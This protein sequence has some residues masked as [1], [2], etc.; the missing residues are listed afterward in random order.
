MARSEED[1]V[2]SRLGIET[3]QERI[4][5]HVRRRGYASIEAM[6][7]RF[8]V[9]TQTIRRDIKHLSALDLLERYH[10][11]AGLPP[12]SD[13]L[14]YSNRKV[15][16]AAAKQSVARAV[17]SRIP[18]GSSLFIDI[19]TTMEAV[20]EALLDHEGLTV[21]TNHIRV[22]A[23]LSQRHDFVINLAGGTVR[24]S[25]QAVTGEATADFI[26]RFKVGFGIF[27][28][29]CIDNDGELLDYDYRDAQ[30]SLAA[31]ANARHVIFAAD[32][33]KFNS[34]AMVRLTHLSEIDALVTNCSP[35]DAILAKLKAN[36]VALT[37]A[38][39]GDSKWGQP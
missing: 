37:V 32:D 28:I 7:E 13:K 31:M 29:G 39:G 16:N 17:A 4:L 12:G 20:A 9:S 21:V 34:D 5:E 30:T 27:S 23:I 25:D 38:A 15:R 22:A 18:N 24:H 3:R 11:G 14:A 10:G 19:G 33:S 2:S 36:D 26:R 1:E 8:S 6:S 35:P